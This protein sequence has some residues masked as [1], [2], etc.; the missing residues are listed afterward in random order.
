MCWLS[1]PLTKKAVVNPTNAN[2]RFFI[3]KTP[4]PE[5]TLRGLSDSE[6]W[7]TQMAVEFVTSN[8]PSGTRVFALNVSSTSELV[9]S[10]DW[11]D[12]GVE[13]KR[14][15]VAEYNQAEV[16]EFCKAVAEAGDGP[17]AFIVYSGRGTN[18]PAFC[19]ASYLAKTA[20]MNIGDALRLCAE[21]FEGSITK[22]APLKALET[23]FEAPGVE[24]AKPA[25]Y[26]STPDVTPVGDVPLDLVQRVRGLEKVSKKV[27]GV[28]KPLPDGPER[29]EI[30]ELV[31]SATEMAMGD[32]SEHFRVDVL[33]ERMIEDMKSVKTFCTF[34]PR[35]Y[36]G[37]IVARKSDEVYFVYENGEVWTL[38]AKTELSKLPAVAMAVCSIQKKRCVM[39]LT[40]LLLLGSLNVTQYPLSVRLGY[41][42]HRFAKEI[43]PSDIEEKEL[44]FLFRP[45]AELKHV[46]NLKKDLDQLVAKCDGIG[47][48]EEKGVPGCYT[49]MPIKPSAQIEVCVN[50]NK[51]AILLAASEDTTV[52][53]GVYTLKNSKMGGLDL[54]TSRFVY[55]T[56]TKDWHPEEIGMCDPPDSLAYIRG[57]KQFMDSHTG[58]GSS[59]SIDSLLDVIAS[60]EY[61]ESK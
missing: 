18:R 53:I 20:G 19:I 30:I 15:V 55:K 28:K 3:E 51:K 12:A 29:D 39:F 60:I 25:W 57:I 6:N 45:M 31:R 11:E 27:Q 38:K 35:G 36:R 13:A 56:D 58:S 24:V 17:V 9:S 1:T 41:L 54:R 26:E 22:E 49:L 42:S 37:F 10:K 44:A 2:V 33:D 59:R 43:K 23:L 34:E 7:T 32:E 61:P 5:A 14:V 16:D 21:S 40:D 50:G 48:Y 47:F 4:L 46:T 52:P 8:V